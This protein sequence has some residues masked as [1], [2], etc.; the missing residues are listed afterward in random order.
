MFEY[1][2]LTGAADK[3]EG[4]KSSNWFVENAYVIL[5]FCYQVHSEFFWK[6]VQL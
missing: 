6:F 2:A 4:E 1:I 3:A 5:S